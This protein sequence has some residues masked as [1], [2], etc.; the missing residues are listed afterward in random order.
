MVQIALGHKDPRMTQQYQKS[1]DDK[2]AA[3]AVKHHS[4]GEE[5]RL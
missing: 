4:I 5:M 2:Y 3:R 1:L